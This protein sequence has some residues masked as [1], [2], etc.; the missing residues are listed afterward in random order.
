MS[1]CRVEHAAY[2]L[3]E[4]EDVDEVVDG[5]PRPG[6]GRRVGPGSGEGADEEE[7]RGGED[8]VAVVRGDAFQGGAYALDGD[9]LVLG[10]VELV[11][12]ALR[13]V[14][15]GEVEG[16]DGEDLVEQEGVGEGEPG[17]VDLPDGGAVLGRV[18]GPE[19]GLAGGGGVVVEELEVEHP[20]CRVVLGLACDELGEVGEGVRGVGRREIFGGGEG[21][22]REVRLGVGGFPRRRPDGP[23]W[24]D[25]AGKRTRGGRLM[26][27]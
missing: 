14:E 24:P 5:G 2:A 12:V 17:Y 22:W 18:A 21:R 11:P 4:H 7:G 25:S 10:G 19:D 1:G 15:V 13:R 6:R 8:G 27:S 16:G 26:P 20:A 3:D 9:R 23:G